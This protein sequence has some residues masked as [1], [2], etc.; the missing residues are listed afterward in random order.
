AGGVI[1]ARHVTGVQTCALP[2]YTPSTMMDASSISSVAVLRKPDIF[3]LHSPK[4]NESHDK[5]SRGPDKQ[6]QPHIQRRDGAVD[7][8]VTDRSEERRVGI[9]CAGRCW[10][11]RR[12]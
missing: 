5:R 11:A 7:G 4:V 8:D 3:F 6:D 9:E 1:G 2:I 10:A 12:T